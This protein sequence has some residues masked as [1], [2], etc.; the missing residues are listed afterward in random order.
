MNTIKAAELGRKAFLNR[1]SATPALDADF[2]AFMAGKPN[3]LELLKAWTTAWHAANMAAPMIESLDPGTTERGYV[4]GWR[5]AE[6]CLSTGNAS[7]M[8]CPGEIATA[9]AAEGFFD[10]MSIH[11]I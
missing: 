10:R 1:K 2:C 9:D 7:N 4:E 8:L 5:L 6:D 3:I 11:Q